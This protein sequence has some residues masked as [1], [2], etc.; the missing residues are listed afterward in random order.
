[1]QTIFQRTNRTLELGFSNALQ[2]MSAIAIARHMFFTRRFSLEMEIRITFLY[3]KQFQQMTRFS[4]ELIEL[5][6]SPS[7]RLFKLSVQINF[8]HPHAFRKALFLKLKLE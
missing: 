6:N 2:I 4:K 5:Y 3:E 8:F 7:A 1:M